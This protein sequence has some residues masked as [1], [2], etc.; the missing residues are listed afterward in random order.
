NR[1]RS[2]CSGEHDDAFAW[3]QRRG[4]KLTRQRTES[5]LDLKSFDM[6]PFAPAIDRVRANGLTL[7]LM[8][9]A[10]LPEELLRQVYE[11]DCT[12]SPD[13]PVWQADDTVQSWEQYRK[14]WVEYP[15]PF[16]VALAL[17]GDRLVGMSTLYFATIP[18]N[19]ASIGYTAVLRE[20]RGRGI[21]MAA[22]L[23]TMQEAMRQGVPSIRT[24]NDPDNPPMLAVNV[25][26][27]F[28]FIPG[29]RLME[30]QI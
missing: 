5:V 6:A 29:P 3:A 11:L 30:K 28:K 17:D 25:K 20:Y 16:V 7:T 14:D 27:G 19:S 24:N 1:V 15:D 2:W 9:G 26:L 23:L 22:K 10:T 12:T 13:V 4:F 21:A 8:D 18:G